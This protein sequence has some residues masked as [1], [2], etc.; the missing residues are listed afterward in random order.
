LADTAIETTKLTALT[1]SA[2]RAMNAVAYSG[3]FVAD[4]TDYH[5]FR[6]ATS[7]KSKFTYAIDN[8]SDKSCT[9]DL[10]GSFD[11]D[12]DPGDTGTFQIGTSITALTDAVAYD[13]T[14]DGFPWLFVRCKFAA[15]PDSKV[16]TVY[17]YAVP[18]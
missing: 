16:V 4:D 17:T 13:T 11:Q 9:I 8:L 6:T 15:T 12:A 2:S 3:T 1:T 10:W 7:G 18:N 5:I 14:A